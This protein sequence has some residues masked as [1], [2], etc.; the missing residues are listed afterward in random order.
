ML[1]GCTSLTSCTVEP[2]AGRTLSAAV[3]SKSTTGRSVWEVGVSTHL[4]ARSFHSTAFRNRRSMLWPTITAVRPGAAS[5]GGR[6]GCTSASARASR[7]RSGGRCCRGSARTPPAGRHPRCCPS[8]RQAGRSRRAPPADGAWG[9][10]DVDGA[11]DGPGGREGFPD[12]DR[13]VV[14][15]AAGARQLHLGGLVLGLD[16][17]RLVHADGSRS[18]AMPPGRLTAVAGVLQ[19]QGTAAV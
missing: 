17:R 19:L 3:D 15:A 14:V 6:C 18:S 8:W 1:C 4:R 12:A 10:A 7:A 11:D 5:R 2:T 13:F 16:V 9:G